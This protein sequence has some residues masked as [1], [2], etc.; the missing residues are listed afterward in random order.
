[1][2]NTLFYLFNDRL[3]A[4]GISNRYMLQYILRQ[5]VGNKYH[6]SR[7]YIS[8]N[9]NTTS[10][11]HEI[12]SY[13][14]DMGC[15][16]TKQDLQNE[17]PGVPANV[18]AFA[19]ADE[20]I[21]VGLGT[22]AHKNYIEKFKVSLQFISREM[23]KIVADGEIHNCQE[24]FDTLKK[25]LPAIIEEVNI[26]DRYFLFSI[27]EEFWADKFEFRRPFFAKTGVN[28]TKQEERIWDFVNSN[29]DTDIVELRGFINE[30][31]FIVNSTLDLIDSLN[32]VVI[33]KNKETLI[34]IDNVA[35]DGSLQDKIDDF[36]DKLIGKN[37]LPIQIDDFSKL[38]ENGIE[39]NEWLLYS[40]VNKYS[41]QFKAV[42]TNSKYAMAEPRFARR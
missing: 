13:I 17:F 40:I 39:W 4:E 16:V 5:K 34:R 2:I 36:L 27:M 20:N 6:L 3:I 31:S 28:I 9:K 42:T 18:F 32:D 19:L 12:V 21:I 38:P 25:E 22:Y 1:M 11:Y 35:F 29:S 10:V 7:D 15:V 14:R 23:N 41:K 26:T 30:N 24:L 33:Y 8:K 37:K